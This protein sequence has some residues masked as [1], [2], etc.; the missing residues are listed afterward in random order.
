MSAARSEIGEGALSD[1]TDTLEASVIKV[2][3]EVTFEGCVT[4]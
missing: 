1:P 3:A 4:L 2:V